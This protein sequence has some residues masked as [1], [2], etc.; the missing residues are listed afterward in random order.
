MKISASFLSIKSNLKD[1]IK[2]LDNTNI[3]YLHLDIMDGKFVLNKTW[4]ISDLNILANHKKPLDVHL[5]VEDIYDYIDLFS[6]LNPEFITFHYEA[7]KDHYL[8]IDYIKSY[9][10]K[11][12]ISINP[13]TDVE[14]LKPYLDLIDLVLVMSVEPG[15]GGQKFQ[16]K[17]INKINQLKKIK[18]DSNYHYMIEID[19]GINNINIENIDADIVVV[20]SFITNDNNY[21]SQINKLRKA[22]KKQPL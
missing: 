3:D 15:M 21:Q 20:G 14:V 1:N 4:N 12:G 6:K 22:L 19:G 5:M 9:N 7:T 18:L 13:D 8:V 17:T 10:I 16:A 2:K 11:V